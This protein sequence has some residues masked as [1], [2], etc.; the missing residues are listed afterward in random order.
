MIGRTNGQIGKGGMKAGIVV[1][2]ENFIDT[3]T[4]SKTRTFTIPEDGLYYL[5][6]GAN[7]TSSINDSGDFIVR[8]TFTITPTGSSAIYYPNLVNNL[9]VTSTQ[10]ANQMNGSPRITLFK[11]LKEGM[12][13]TAFANCTTLTQ[14]LHPYQDKKM[15]GIQI[16]KIDG[17][18]P[19]EC[20]YWDNEFVYG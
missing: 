20:S 7:T 9:Q 19:S 1:V 14:R 10:V 18:I 13:V 3:R 5:Y 4:A 6:L 8:F 15:N 2:D 17:N 12:Q 11:Y 16:I